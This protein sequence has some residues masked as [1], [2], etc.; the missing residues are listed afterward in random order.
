[1]Q[2]TADCL[3]MHRNKQRIESLSVFRFNVHLDMWFHTNIVN[4]NSAFSSQH[5]KVT[6]LHTLHNYCN[7]FQ[8]HNTTYSFYIQISIFVNC[9]IQATYFVMSMKKNTNVQ[10]HLKY[11]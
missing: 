10:R 5:I 7:F 4:R 1:L 2:I 3:S 11:S 6:E 9:K 8:L